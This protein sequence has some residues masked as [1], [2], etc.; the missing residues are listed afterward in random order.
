MNDYIPERLK[1]LS[2][3]EKRVI[4]RVIERIE[5]KPKRQKYMWGHIVLTVLI[6]IMPILFTINEFYIEDHDIAST[7]SSVDFTKPLFSETDGRIYISGISLGDASSS[8][9]GLLGK[10]Y[11]KEYQE[12]GSAADLILDYQGQARFYFYEDKLDSIIILE[13]DEEY[14]ENVYHNYDGIKFISYESRYIYSMENNQLVKVENIPNGN[15]QLSFSLAG[16]DLL[17]NAEFK[18]IMTTLKGTK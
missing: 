1:D 2:K 4:Q 15:L 3:N 9:I 5:I 10:N 12:D 7:K 8:V 14:F 17:E 11:T 13:L 16:P 6:L 18:E